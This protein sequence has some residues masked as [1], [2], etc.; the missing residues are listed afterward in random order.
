MVYRCHDAVFAVILNQLG[1]LI[2]VQRCSPTGF[3]ENIHRV[4]K[5]LVFKAKDI[6][7]TVFQAIMV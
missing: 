6:L 1:H 7:A 3:F 2:P 4:S 5:M